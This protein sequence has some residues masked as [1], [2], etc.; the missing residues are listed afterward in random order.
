[1]L[2]ARTLMIAWASS[3]RSTVGMTALTVAMIG[4]TRADRA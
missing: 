4:L 3:G 2:C 1:V